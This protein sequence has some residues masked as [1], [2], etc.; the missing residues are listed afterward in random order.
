MAVSLPKSP[1]GTLFNQLLKVTRKQSVLTFT[2]F[3]HLAEIWRYSGFK[4]WNLGSNHKIWPYL[5]QLVK[6][7]K[8][9][10]FGV[11]G[12]NVPYFWEFGRVILILLF[13]V[14][15]IIAQLKIHT[16]QWNNNPRLPPNFYFTAWHTNSYSKFLSI[17]ILGFWEYYSSITA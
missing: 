9:P 13:Y 5:G 14:T 8:L 15:I 4:T 6:N 7:L 11:Q 16:M 10:T 1:K 3:D 12:S 17:S 2:F